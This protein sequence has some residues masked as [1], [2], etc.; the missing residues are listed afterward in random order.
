MCG[1]DSRKLIWRLWADKSQHV[2][3][4]LVDGQRAALYY[5]VMVVKKGL[6]STNL[7][8]HETGEFIPILGI[9]QPPK[10]PSLLTYPLRRS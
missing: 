3:N 10:M 5:S 7:K 2:Q 8:L 1:A 9:A 4:L 6:G